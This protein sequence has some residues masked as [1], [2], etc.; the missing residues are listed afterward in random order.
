VKNGL[1]SIPGIDPVC[2]YQGDSSAFNC[3]SL[4]FKKKCIG[5]SRESLVSSF[6]SI[7]IPIHAG[8]V[9]IPIH[10]RSTFQKKFR[11][12]FQI[13]EDSSH[14]KGSCPI[15]EAR[16]MNEELQLLYS[17]ELIEILRIRIPQ[18]NEFLGNSSTIFLFQ[19]SIK[20]AN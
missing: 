2:C 13:A 20:I 9:R 8:P 14:Q 7:G 19:S 6:Q 1:K 3:I 4:T 12:C 18:M 15:A 5:T 16:C 10:Q 11:N 17:T